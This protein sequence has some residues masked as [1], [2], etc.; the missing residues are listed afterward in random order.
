MS[1]CRP[2]NGFILFGVQG[3]QYS[4]WKI[5]DLDD[6]TKLVSFYLFGEIHRQHW[7]L[8][9]GSV[10]GLLNANIMQSSEH[11]S[12]RWWHARMNVKIM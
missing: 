3:K 7:K 8:T 9:V 2:T 11:V 12:L 1:L 10:I 4:T 6:C 5:S